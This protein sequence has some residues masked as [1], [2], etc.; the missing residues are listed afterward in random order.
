MIS[1]VAATPKS[2]KPPAPGS[3]LLGGW[4]PGDKKHFPRACSNDIWNSIDGL[5]WSLIKTNSFIDENFDPT[6]DWEGRP[7]AGY[8]VFQNTMWI[9]FQVKIW[10][11]GGQSL[12]TCKPDVGN[13]VE[14]DVWKIVRKEL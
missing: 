7:T 2:S 12:S 10:V 6:N 4:N 9:D 3:G 5:T 11:M 8:A 1:Q 13:N 14:S